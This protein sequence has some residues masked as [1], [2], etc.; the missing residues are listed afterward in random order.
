[1]ADKANVVQ[2]LTD[3][4]GGIVR[5]VRP[6]KGEKAKLTQMCVKN[7]KLLLG[8]LIVQQQSR[9]DYIAFAVQQLQKDLSLPELPKRIEAFDIS[10]IQGKDAVASLVA[11]NNGSADKKNYRVFKIKTKDTPDDF[12]MI[13]EAVTRR[14]SRLLKEDADMPDLVLIDGGKGQ[15]SSAVEALEKI[16]LEDIP[17]I[18]LAKRLDEVFVPGISEPQNIQKSSSGL[19]L[20]QRVRDEAHRFALI[21]HR[22]QRKKRMIT[23]ELDSIPGIGP[24]RKRLLLKYFGSLSKLKGAKPDS[25]ASVR[26]ISPKLA[27]KIFDQLNKNG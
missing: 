25:I 20:L 26:S 10:N 24:E 18:G 5:I 3:K 11:F 19:K 2:W 9:K 1:V 17:V 23:S 16:S 14:Y 22:K 4:R 8:E 12:A 21:P 15:L 13:A 27:E 6:Q 7:A